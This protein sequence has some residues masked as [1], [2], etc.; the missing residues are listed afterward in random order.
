MSRT[1]PLL[2]MMKNRLI[3]YLGEECW[4]TYRTQ[5][6]RSS[7]TQQPCPLVDLSSKHRS[8]FHVIPQQVKVPCTRKVSHFVTMPKW[9][10]KP[11]TPQSYSPQ[12]KNSEIPLFPRYFESNHRNNGYRSDVLLSRWLSSHPRHPVSFSFYRSDCMLRLLGRMSRQSPLPFADWIGIDY[13][14]QLYRF[15]VG[16]PRMF[17][18]LLRW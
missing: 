10:I 14:R 15:K 6:V 7:Y 2:E 11:S 13:Q 18:L 16:K 8:M 1:Q 9:Q 5:T 12:F 4:P 17:V 3:K